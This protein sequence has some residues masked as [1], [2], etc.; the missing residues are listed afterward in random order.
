MHTGRARVTFRETFEAA[1]FPIVVHQDGQVVYRNAATDDMLRYLGI[2]A[3]ALAGEADV[4]AFV[5][6]DELAA[7]LRQPGRTARTVTRTL[8]AKDGRPHAFL[9][10]V[11]QTTWGDRPALWLGLLWAPAMSGRDTALPP[12]RTAERRPASLAVLTPRERQVATLLARGYSTLN[13]A[14]LLGLTESTVRDHVK[15]IFRKTGVHS[16]VEL[17]R[18][19]QD[20]G[21]EG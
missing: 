7:T 18:L 13:T 14:T 20:V 1:P 6:P 21:E 16:R 11:V 19:V 17:T 2:E 15:A 12:A 5:P 8:V 4:F 10:S 3:E 9:A